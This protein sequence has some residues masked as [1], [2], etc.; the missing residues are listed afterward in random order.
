MPKESSVLD[1]A[2]ESAPLE[3]VELFIDLQPDI[4]PNTIYKNK[5]YL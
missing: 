2:I 4:W 3:E 1:S 5:K